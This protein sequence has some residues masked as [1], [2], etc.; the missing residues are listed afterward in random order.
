MLIRRWAIA[1]KRGHVAQECV[2][3]SPR[4]RLPT[5]PDALEH[6]K[7]RGA[8]PSA[9][10]SKRPTAASCTSAPSHG[11]VGV[12]ARRL[13]RAGA[14]LD[15]AASRSGKRRI[16]AVS[17]WGRHRGL[18]ARARTRAWGELPPAQPGVV[19]V[20]GVHTRSL[21]QARAPAVAP[22]SATIANSRTCCLGAPQPAS[23]QRSPPEARSPVEIRA[24]SASFRP[25]FLKESPRRT[26]HF[27]APPE[28]SVE[29]AEVWST[30]FKSKLHGRTSPTWLELDP[31]FV[32][33]SQSC[34]NKSKVGRT[35]HKS[36]QIAPKSQMWLTRKMSPKPTPSVARDGP[37]FGRNLHDTPNIGQHLPKFC[38]S[39]SRLGRNAQTPQTWSFRSTFVRDHPELGRA[40]SDLVET[41]PNFGR[42]APHS[43]KVVESFAETAQD[44]VEAH[45]RVGRRVSKRWSTRQTFGQHPRLRFGRLGR[46]FPEI[47]PTLL[48]A[49]PNIGVLLSAL[50]AGGL[51]AAV[52]GPLGSPHRPG[53]RGGAVRQ[54]PVCEKEEVRPGRLRHSLLLSRADGAGALGHRGGA[55]PSQGGV[56]EGHRAGGG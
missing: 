38:R 11:V 15:V 46:R 25:E 55:D 14:R 2:K 16:G 30:P 39:H 34:P 53:G 21:V 13:A 7:E 52:R 23:P 43:N 9:I 35:I 37:E 4:R 12:T 17:A 47:A 18:A 26:Q 48:G 3:G 28:I 54:R 50:A 45:S 51:G 27:V 49:A 40:C 29:S 56:G 8:Q 44:L 24:M 31:N 42:I 5:P 10:S 32:Y 33:M 19:R 20:P 36:G 41:P 6:V 22:A 1:R